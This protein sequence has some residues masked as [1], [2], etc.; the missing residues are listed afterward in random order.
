MKKVDESSE[1][2]IKALK[3]TYAAHGDKSVHDAQYIA[4]GILI[5]LFSFGKKD[6]FIPY[7]I[8]ASVTSIFAIFS[9]FLMCWYM[10]YS[11]Y[12]T[13]RIL[14]LSKNNTADDFNVKEQYEEF[15]IKS[16]LLFKVF[17][18]VLIIAVALFMI[19]SFCYFWGSLCI[20]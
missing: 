5:A 11:F 17:L 1:S 6:F 16:L 15:R 12:K 7:P 14:L 19:S 13:R 8:L 20:C 10:V 2:I 9:L 3:D 4:Y 18:A